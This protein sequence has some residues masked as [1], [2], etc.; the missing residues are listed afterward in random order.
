MLRYWWPHRN[1]ICPVRSLHPPS[2]WHHLTCISTRRV[3]SCYRSAGEGIPRRIWHARVHYRVQKSQPLVSVPTHM[4]PVYIFVSCLFK[5][6]LN[7]SLPSALSSLEWR[8]PPGFRTKILYTCPE[9]LILLDFIALIFYENCRSAIMKLFVMKRSKFF[10]YLY[11]GF[12]YCP[13][14]PVLTTSNMRYSISV[15]GRVSHP[16]VYKLGFLTSKIITLFKMRQ[17]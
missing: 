2:Y 11:L 5:I 17:A 15:K 12:K 3:P 4:N 1:A 14:R 13:Q 16:Y 8:F 6:R 7:I 10:C 9:H